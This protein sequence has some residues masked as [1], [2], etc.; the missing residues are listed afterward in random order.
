MQQVNE[1]RVFKSKF[2]KTSERKKQAIRDDFA[3]LPPERRRRAIQEK[4]DQLNLDK[5]K[6][7]KVGSLEPGV[8][9]ALWRPCAL[10][11]RNKMRFKF[12]YLYGPETCFAPS[13]WNVGRWDSKLSNHELL[14]PF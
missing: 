1:K 5:A 8:A 12:I 2:F 3:H 9:G 10:S 11:I 6:E 7:A 13:T 14:A 4:V